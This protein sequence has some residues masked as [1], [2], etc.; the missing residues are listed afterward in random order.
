MQHLANPR[1]TVSP[2]NPVQQQLDDDDFPALETLRDA[3]AAKKTTRGCSSS[4]IKSKG[5][6]IPLSEF[7]KIEKPIANLGTPAGKQLKQNSRLKEDVTVMKNTSV[8]RKTV[9]VTAVSTK[10]GGS[11]QQQRQLT[12]KQDHPNEAREK[13][14]ASVKAGEYKLVKRPSNVGDISQTQGKDA[15]MEKKK[16][17]RPKK[18]QKTQNDG[19]KTMESMNDGGEQEQDEDEEEKEEWN[20]PIKNMKT[21]KNPSKFKREEE[22]EAWNELLHMVTEMKVEEIVKRRPKRTPRKKVS[23]QIM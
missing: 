7:L 21:M 5:K 23:Y 19:Q 12:H 4:K 6:A 1:H 9:P 11:K 18:T 20:E 14:C 3:A 15:K 10:N 16:P 17:R 22:E 13:K 2:A 8:K